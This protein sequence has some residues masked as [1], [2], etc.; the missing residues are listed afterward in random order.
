MRNKDEYY[1]YVRLKEINEIILQ[2]ILF[3]QFNKA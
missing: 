1:L 2:W 3:K